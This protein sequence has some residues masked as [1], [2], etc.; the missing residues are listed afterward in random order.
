[1][2]KVGDKIVVVK[3]HVCRND[4]ITKGDIYTV[5]GFNPH[6]KDAI[7][8]KP[9]KPVGWFITN[10]KGE[11]YFKKVIDIQCQKELAEKALQLT[12]E[13]LDVPI[14]EEELTEKLT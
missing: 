1:M 14:K 13:T 7:I 5:L 9:H 11:P 12:R 4:S 10:D 8:I 2:F 6:F 3:S